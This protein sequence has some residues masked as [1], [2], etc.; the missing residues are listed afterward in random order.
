MNELTA[1]KDDF[2]KEFNQ[3]S[4]IIGEQT[5]KFLKLVYPSYLVE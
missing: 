4:Q 1:K 2:V 5:A 3:D